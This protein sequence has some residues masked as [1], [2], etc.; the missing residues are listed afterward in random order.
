MQGCETIIA[1]E[2]H[3]S[4]RALASELGATHVLDPADGELAEQVR[5][6]R[7]AGV[8]YVF[9][10]TGIPSV[11]TSALGAMAPHGSL[12]LVGV[13]AD[14]AASVQLNLMQAMIVGVRIYGII[15]GDAVPDDFIPRMVELHASGRFPFDKMI[16]KFPFAQIN[17]AAEA[18]GRGEV[19]K[20]VLIQD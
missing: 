10:T 18:Q 7:P 12:G 20:V 16:T 8:Q 17:E 14:P 19:V 1:L 5:A 4:R 11:I 6:I 2:P 9:D 3:G 13:P 15:E